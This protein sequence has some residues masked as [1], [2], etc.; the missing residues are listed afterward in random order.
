M[1]FLS[2]FLSLLRLMYLRRY[3]LQLLTPASISATSAGRSQIE[4]EDI[5]EMREIFLDAKTS[6]R[7]V[8]EGGFSGG[9]SL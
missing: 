6:A 4:L 5:N 8:G 7:N 9:A 2:S 3:V 1:E